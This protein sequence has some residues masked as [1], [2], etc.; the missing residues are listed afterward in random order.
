[1]VQDTSLNTELVGRS[2]DS[3]VG[4]TTGS[5]SRTIRVRNPVKAKNL[6]LLHNVRTSFPGGKV[7][8]SHTSTPPICLHGVETTLPLLWCNMFLRN[9]Y[10]TYQTAWC[11]NLE[12]PVLKRRDHNLNRYHCDRLKPHAHIY[13]LLIGVRG[14]VLRKYKPT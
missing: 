3:I 11:Y 13:A 5:M 9:V 14:P 6:S 12:N 1:M 8:R 7:P 10:N 2:T 4:V